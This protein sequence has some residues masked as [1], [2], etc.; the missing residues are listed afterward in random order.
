VIVYFLR[1]I[2]AATVV[3]LHKGDCS[4]FWYGCLAETLQKQG[5]KVS[6]WLLKT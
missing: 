6:A 2:C 1:T 5:S 3:V 4:R